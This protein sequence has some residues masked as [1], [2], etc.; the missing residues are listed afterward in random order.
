MGKLKVFYGC[1]LEGKD[2]MKLYKLN[3]DFFQN[4]TDGFETQCDFSKLE[5]S[6]IIKLLNNDREFIRDFIKNLNKTKKISDNLLDSITED[7]I[8]SLQGNIIDV[9]NQ[10][11]Y[12]YKDIYFLCDYKSKINTV[13]YICKHI[14]L[15]FPS[16]FKIYEIP[17]ESESD[18]L[19][20]Q[21]LINE[22]DALKEILHPKLF[23][24][25]C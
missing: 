17:T 12:K 18:R 15:V 1:Y 6:D 8:D 22:D 7:F 9:M 4:L 16:V 5:D 23:F 25:Y 20:F 14:D 11:L 19:L 3:N 24:K 10:I 13:Y 21:N 2:M